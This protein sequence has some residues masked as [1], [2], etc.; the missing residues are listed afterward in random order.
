MIVT[1]QINIPTTFD[2]NVPEFYNKAKELYIKNNGEQTDDFEQDLLD[3]L[4]YYLCELNEEFNTAYSK[5]DSAE[6]EWSVNH[7]DE[8]LNCLSDSLLE[9]MEELNND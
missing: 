8:A 7:V 4:V 5:L 9:Y 1:I 2:I 3:N 6:I